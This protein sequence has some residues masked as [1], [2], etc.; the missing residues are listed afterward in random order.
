MRRQMHLWLALDVQLARAKAQTVPR[1]VHRKL[2]ESQDS[3]P[4][5]TT[6]SIRGKDATDA[7]QLL[8]R[9]AT[10][11]GHTRERVFSNQDRQARFF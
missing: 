6:A 7:V 8:Q 2:P 9:Q 5:G 4:L 1:L 11:A 3:G 10:T